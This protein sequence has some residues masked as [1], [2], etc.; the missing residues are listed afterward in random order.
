VAEPLEVAELVAAAVT[1][2]DTMMDLE[3]TVGAAADAG[4]VALVDAVADLAPRPAVADEDPL[5]LSHL[6]GW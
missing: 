5:V 3:P 2:R 4:S 6:S 1:E